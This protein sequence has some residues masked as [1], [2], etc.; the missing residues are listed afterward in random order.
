MCR[1]FFLLVFA[2]CSAL[3]AA[4]QVL[5]GFVTEAISGEP[6]EGVNV[7]LYG[8]GEISFGAATDSDGFYLLPRLTPGKYILRTSYVGYVT[9]VDS[10]DIG[11][12]QGIHQLDI[13]LEED[14]LLL[15]QLT[16]VDN[17]GGSTTLLSA[18]IERITPAAIERVPMPDITADLSA[19][20]ATLP[21]VVLVGDQGGQFYVRGGEPTQNLVLLDGMLIYQP[22][23]ILSYYTA[24]PSEVLR[25]V[26][27][28]AGGFGPRFGGRISSVVDAWSRNGNSSRFAASGSVSP[29]LV[30]TQVEGPIVAGG[31]FTMIASARQSVVEDAAANVI[32]QD[33]PLLFHDLFAKI[34]GRPNRNGRVSVSGIKTYDRGRVGGTRG[35]GAPDEVRWWNDAVGGRY[36]FLPGNLPVLAE[37]LMSWSGHTMQLG[38]SED[39]IRTSSTSRINME[40]NVTHYSRRGDLHWGLFARSLTLKSELG[41]LYQ[42]LDLKTEYV[43][44]AG[45]YA[46]PEFKLSSG[47]SIS[48]GLRIHHFPSKD[49]L[50]IEPRLRAKTVLGNN[51]L[52]AAVGLYHQE[53]VG[54]SDRRDAASVFTAWTAVPVG[55]IPR[56]LHIIMGYRRALAEGMTIVTDLY[57]KRMSNLYIAEWTARPR[58]TTKL[59]QADG[60]VLG[61]D[62]RLEYSRAP[63]YAYINYGLASTEYEAM[64][65]E[66]VHWFNEVIYKFRPAH[67]RRHQINAM[68]STSIYGFDVSLRWQFGSG[69]PFNRAYGF[70]GFLLMDGSVDVFTEAGERRVIYERPF[71]GILPA[72]HRLDASVNRAFQIGFSRVTLQ[73]SVINVYDRAN[74]FYLDVFT[75]ERSDQLP[76]IPSVGIKVDLP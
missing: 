52:S 71:N 22:F 36:L 68:F 14:E 39:L 66:L 73:A 13:A 4:S 61:L 6:L 17:A 24:F 19:Y 9:Y 45:I 49:R 11:P 48:P 8:E 53:L 58:L 76:L 47:T 43:T 75:L 69:R 64:Q 21:G 26:D 5:R 42:N 29:F 63:Y 56:A 2:V 3:P 15:E 55:D 10:L 25:S 74:V 50:L 54:I 30:G 44:E 16:V 70:D 32:G 46:A 59:Q 65:S 31:R 41:G 37:F 60:R 27:L 40:A 67:D 7:V 57:Y 28:H 35:V 38:P 18:G 34:H 51:E 1:I 33:I 23:H 20:L 12:G 62:L 72:Y